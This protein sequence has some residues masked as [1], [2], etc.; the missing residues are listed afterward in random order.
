MNI[1]TLKICWII[2][3]PTIMSW[4]QDVLLSKESIPSWLEHINFVIMLNLYNISIVDYFPKNGES[5][6]HLVE[7]NPN[8]PTADTKKVSMDWINNWLIKNWD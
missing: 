2:T 5:C 4:T 7:F 1:Y 3:F 8:N 6:I